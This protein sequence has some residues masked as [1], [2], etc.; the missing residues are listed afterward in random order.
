MKL[1]Y[2]T[3]ACSLSPHIILREAG[4]SP[5]LVRVDLKAHKTE[6]GKDFYAINPKGYIPA[7][8]L[9]DGTLLTEGVAI[10]LYL[11]EKNPKAN[12]TP[13][14]GSKDYYKML[15]YMIF[16]STELHKSFVPLFS[17]AG[18]KAREVYTARLEQRFAF[19]SKQLGD[20]P[21][22]MG[23]QF[24]LPDAYLF[25]V[26][27]WAESLKLNLT[28]SPNLA[29]FSKRVAARPAVQAALKAEGLLE[30]KAA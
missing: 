13:A 30:V 28:A 9:E 16:I 25:T 27:R 12:L 2:S 23:E 8:E 29:A 15:E 26:L 6:D 22:L 7:L 20:K 3:G 24:T 14:A 1:Y 21:Y 11:G 17:D 19:I 10:N 5:E 4:I 18:E